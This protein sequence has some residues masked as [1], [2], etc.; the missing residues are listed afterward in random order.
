MISVANNCDNFIFEDAEVSV[1]LMIYV[2]YISSRS[3][4]IIDVKNVMMYSN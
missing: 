3:E 2:N 1:F 4:G